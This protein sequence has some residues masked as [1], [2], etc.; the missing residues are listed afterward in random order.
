M[1]DS[2]P[3]TS[4][5][6]SP[7]QDTFVQSLD[8][9]SKEPLVN[10]KPMHHTVRKSGK[11]I[12][13]PIQL[14]DYVTQG[15]G[16]K[17]KNTCLYPISAVISYDHLS[18]PYQSFVAH[19]SNI[20]K[21]RSYHEVAENSKWIEV[22]KVEIY[23]L[24]EN[25]TWEVMS[26]PKGKKALGANGFTRSS[27]RQ[28]VKWEGLRQGQWQKGTTKRMEL[29]TKKYSLILSKWSMLEQ[30]FPQLQLRVGPY[31]KWMCTIPSCK[32]ICMS[33]YTWNVLK[34]SVL[35]M[36]NIKYADYTSP[37]MGLNK[38][39]DSGTLS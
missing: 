1:A 28:M 25:K 19:V 32:V 29:T 8:P 26:L 22:M 13:P 10:I 14:K 23:A 35:K 7:A 2:L 31:T 4:S 9:T 15:K 6:L 5:S 34:V 17:V 36:A 11:V 37:S 27:T 21:T 38:Y 3:T 30:L 12:M 33:K 24:E 20:T 16:Q 39:P 18:K